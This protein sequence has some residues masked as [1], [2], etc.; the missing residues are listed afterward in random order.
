MRRR[1]PVV[2]LAVV[3]A[4]VAGCGGGGKKSPH[5]TDDQYRAALNKLCTSGNRQVAAL[6]LTT[7]MK[8]W[9]QNG[10]KA[11]KIADQTVKGFEALTPPDD[12]RS[13]ADKYTQASEDIVKAV[14]DAA[15]AAKT[16]D[17]KAFDDA[18]SRQQNSS[19]QARSY[20]SQLGATGCAG[21]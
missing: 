20:A 15:R 12:L 18:L 2:V 17:A 21:G 6:R 16:G 3:V 8:T 5:L 14:G 9:K 19:L 11:A 4:V 7:S 13:T 10:Q 1:L